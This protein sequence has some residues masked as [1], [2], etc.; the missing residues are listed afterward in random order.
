VDVQLNTL[1]VVADRA[2]VRR[3]HLTLQVE[4]ERQV[5]LSVP[6][7]QRNR[8]PRSAAFMLHRERWAS[9]RSMG[10]LSTS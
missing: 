10:S 6:V 1:Y 3:D 8:S 5:R 4:V 2:T 7:H 9:A